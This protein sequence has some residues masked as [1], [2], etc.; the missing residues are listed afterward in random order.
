MNVE[1]QASFLLSSYTLI[2]RLFSSSYLSAI[3][4]YQDIETTKCSWTDEWIK[5]TWYLYT[6]EFYSAINMNEIMPFVATCM[7]LGIIILSEDFQTEDKYHMI[8]LIF[9]I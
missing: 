9:G 6:M 1:F 8:P 3:G 7:G 5:K 4:G 2:K